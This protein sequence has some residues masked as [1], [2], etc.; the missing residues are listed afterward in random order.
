[1]FETS[2]AHY[3]G[4]SGRIDL[5][6]NT[7]AMRDNAN[8]S[9]QMEIK[10][11]R[12]DCISPHSPKLSV[13]ATLLTTNKASYT[14]TLVIQKKILDI[15]QKLVKNPSWCVADKLGFSSPKLINFPK[16]QSG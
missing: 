8:K 7:L 1:M 12:F 10:H 15:E 16:L 11:S 5:E 2:C 13:S 6:R 14:E 4:R 3:N 9:F